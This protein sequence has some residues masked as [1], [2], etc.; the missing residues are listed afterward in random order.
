MPRS[1]LGK[2]G[3]PR[4]GCN[5]PA[6]QS[7]AQKRPCG[8][9]LIITFAASR[10]DRLKGIHIF[11]CRK[12]WMLSFITPPPANCLRRGRFYDA[13]APQGAGAG[14]AR[15]PRSSLGKRETPGEG[16]TMPAL[17][18][19]RLFLPASFLFASL[20]AR[21]RGNPRRGCNDARTFCGQ[22]IFA[23]K[24]FVCLA[25][26][27]A[28]GEPPARVQR[29]PHFLRAGYFCRQ[30]FC[31]PRSSLGKRGTPGEGSP[32]RKLSTGQIF[33]PLPALRFA[34]CSAS[35]EAV[36]GVAPSTPTS[37]LKKA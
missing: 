23:G 37:L 5:L 16:A 17:S 7:L 8:L 12:I 27:S 3:N 20:I 19:G 32:T 34:G 1:P 25:H 31:L 36:R 21:Q 6:Q 29:C 24:F 9:R 11:L 33:A 35:A 2:V 10:I 26:R 18:A 13:P 15:L 22:V 28:K 30:V 14:V 4:R